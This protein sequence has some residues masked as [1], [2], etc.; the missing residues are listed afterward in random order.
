MT[1]LWETYPRVAVCGTI[2]VGKST[3]AQKLAQHLQR[4]YVGEPDGHDTVWPFFYAKPEERAFFMQTFMGHTRSEMLRQTSGPLV[5]D[6]CLSEDHLFAQLQT[7]RGGMTPIEWD[8]YQALWHTWATP[9]TTPDLILYLRCDPEIAHQRIRQR[10]R[11]YEQEIELEYLEAL[12]ERYEAWVQAS[13]IPVITLDWNV[14]K[15]EDYV[16]RAINAP[17]PVPLSEMT[18]AC[19][20]L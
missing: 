8:L 10:G 12:Q 4:T 19:R 17:P 15:G 18:D 6:R 11:P 3:L 2:G 16:L 9:D 20:I 5:M 14:P 13:P 1:D 7:D